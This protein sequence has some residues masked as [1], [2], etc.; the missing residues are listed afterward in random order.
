MKKLSTSVSPFLMLIVPVLFAVLL[1][2]GFNTN[3]NDVDS[4]LTTTVTTKTT[5][6]KLVKTGE[7]TIIKFL[8]KK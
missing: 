5:A 3:N 2:L 1:S 6:Q 4:E 7:T 8:M